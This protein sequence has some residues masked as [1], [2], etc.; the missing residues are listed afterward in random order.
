MMSSSNADGDNEGYEVLRLSLWNHLCYNNMLLKSYYVNPIDP[1]TRPHCLYLFLFDK[2]AMLTLALWTSTGQGDS[3]IRWFLCVLFSLTGS[4]TCLLRWCLDIKSP[5]RSALTYL[6]YLSSAICT[7]VT[8][9]QILSQLGNIDNRAIALQT[10]SIW[11]NSLYSAILGSFISDTLSFYLCF[12]TPCCNCCCCNY[13]VMLERR[14]DG[15]VRY[16][17]TKW[18]KK[19]DVSKENCCETMPLWASC[20]VTL[21]LPCC[22]PKCRTDGMCE[23][24]C[25]IC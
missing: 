4:L 21:G 16:E 18:S 3:W 2:V 20:L 22:R 9:Q 6:F 24:L 12:N 17:K 19:E 5:T 7:I 15:K 25:F 8:L 10:L 23:C 11:G 13:Y 14:S 1:L